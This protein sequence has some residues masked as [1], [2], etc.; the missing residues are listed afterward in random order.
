M[1]RGQ[2]IPAVEAAPNHISDGFGGHRR[3]GAPFGDIAV[4]VKNAIRGCPL[5]QRIDCNT[6]GRTSI[7]AFLPP[8]I[9]P[10]VGSA[11]A[12]ANGALPF[13]KCGK[14]L[15]SPRCIG[16]RVI[17]I[18]AGHGMVCR[19]R[20]AKVRLDTLL[21]RENG[22]SMHRR[23]IDS[24]EIVFAIRL[25]GVSPSIGAPCIS[26]QELQIL[27]PCYFKPIDQ[28]CTRGKL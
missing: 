21:E 13:F 6:P 26:P 10:R 15:A 19:F 11:I 9:S 22:L 3:I 1:L 8:G 7:T 23:D 4:Q 5:W 27:T 17:P 24:R 2:G 18:H 28:K 16:I 20:V 25:I 12:S 14:S